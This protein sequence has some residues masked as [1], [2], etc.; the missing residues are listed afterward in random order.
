MIFKAE[1][2]GVVETETHGFQKIMEKWE[3]VKAANPNKQE[4]MEEIEGLCLEISIGRSEKTIQEE[5][6][7]RLIL[8]LKQ[9]PMDL[10]PVEFSMA[11]A[12]AFAVLAGGTF[13][14]KSL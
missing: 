1:K 14:K 5:N 8:K 13:G 9:L 4:L 7:K 11:R 2:L 6:L 10:G 12:Y 3:T